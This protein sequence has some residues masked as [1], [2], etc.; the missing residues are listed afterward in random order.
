[1]PVITLEAGKIAKEEKDALILELTK[2]ASG[3]LNIPEQSFVVFLK[4]NE[5]DNIGRGGKAL[6][7][8]RA[9]RNQK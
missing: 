8:V 5:Y 3:I 7:Q 4:E 2:T 6:S 1:M 9:E